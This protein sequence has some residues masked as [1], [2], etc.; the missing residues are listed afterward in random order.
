MNKQLGFTLLE[1]LITV[2]ISALLITIAAP[3]FQ[4]YIAKNKVQTEARKLQSDISFARSEA[5]TGSKYIS[6][7]ASTD[8][9]SCNGSSDW[10][11]GWIVFEDVG[12]NSNFANIDT[13]NSAGEKVLRYTQQLKSIDIE[14]TDTGG[15]GI[16]GM[17]FSPRG[18]MDGLRRSNT[19]TAISRATIKVCEPGG[20][21]SHA[22]AILMEMTGRS[23]GS[24]DN[25]SNGVH[26]DAAGSNLSC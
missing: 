4:D 19:D 12:N 23:M 11:G 21:V 2:A 17:M 18:Y 8:G 25:D 5:V 24:N 7:C 15:E 20:N 26:E 3:S 10:S 1:L 16:L 22:R 13:N 6:I 9:K 14:A